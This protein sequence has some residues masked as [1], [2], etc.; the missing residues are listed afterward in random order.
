MPKSFMTLED[1]DAYL[2]VTAA[3]SFKTR[4]K[5]PFPPLKRAP[6]EAR[7]RGLVRHRCPLHGGLVA[8][9]PTARVTCACGR[10]AVASGVI[11]K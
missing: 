7:S 10:E 9:Y 8:T 1:L 3:P 2:G 5:S 6:S 11:R 4:H